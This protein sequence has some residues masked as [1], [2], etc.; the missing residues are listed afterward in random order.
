MGFEG[1]WEIRKAVKRV[2]LRTEQPGWSLQVVD[3]TGERTR[4]CP[5]VFKGPDSVGY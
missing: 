4:P 1:G 3:T 2:K 5:R